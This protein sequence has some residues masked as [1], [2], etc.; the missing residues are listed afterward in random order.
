MDFEYVPQNFPYVPLT[1]YGRVIYRDIYDRWWVTRF[2]YLY[3]EGTI[4]RFS[5]YG[6]YNREDQKPYD[7][8][9]AALAA[10]SS[11]PLMRSIPSIGA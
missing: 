5:P 10:K 11:G 2:C 7:T 9:E 8:Y 6:D 3:L 4:N 1:V